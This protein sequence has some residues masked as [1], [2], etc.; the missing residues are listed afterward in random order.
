MLEPT[1]DGL[2]LA[3]GPDLKKS[4][5]PMPSG[6][7]SLPRTRLVPHAVALIGSEP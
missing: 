4:P 6:R 1:R 2:R 5:E 7:S 3:A